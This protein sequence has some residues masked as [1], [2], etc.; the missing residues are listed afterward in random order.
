MITKKAKAK[1]GGS[2]YLVFK[3]SNLLAFTLKLEV[4]SMFVLAMAL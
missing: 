1:L 4:K 2:S 3:G